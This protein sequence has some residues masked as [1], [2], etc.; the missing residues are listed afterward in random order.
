MM[1]HDDEDT[2]PAS[3]LGL[4]IA[5]VVPVPLTVEIEAVT[6]SF[7]QK[8][9]EVSGTIAASA[10]KGNDPLMICFEVDAGGMPGGHPDREP[11]VLHV[12]TVSRVSVN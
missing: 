5:H 4:P 7:A 8:A 12:H 10:G 9:S 2:N 3:M 11:T 1:D 6:L